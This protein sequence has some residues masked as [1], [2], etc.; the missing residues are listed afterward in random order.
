MPRLIYTPLALVDVV[1]LR[2]FIAE[3]NPEAAARMAR[4]IKESAAR[5]KVYPML[6]IQVEEMLFRDMAIPFG[7]NSYILRYRLIMET[8]TVVVVGIRHGKED[9]GTLDI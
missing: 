6:G 9:T 8:Q 7:A 5:L 4:I 1:R 2:E 3:H